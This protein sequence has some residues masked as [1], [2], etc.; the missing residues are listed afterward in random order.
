MRVKLV[1]ITAIM[2]FILFIH[3][4]LFN[5]FTITDEN[6]GKIVFQ[7]KIEKY[8][9]FYTSFT[10]SV[11]RTPVNE[12]Y[13]ISQGMFL[14]KKAAFYSYGAGMPEAGE[15]GSSQPKI[16]DG[17]VQ[18]DHIDKVF[19]SLTIFAGT[20]ADHS[21]NTKN[22]KISFSQLVKPQTSVTFEV[23]RISTFAIIRL[24]W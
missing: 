13:E 14:L 24:Q 3:I 22:K 16:V 1:C 17:L 6:S 23:K 7:D 11:N 20:Y 5:R 12:Y 15:Y 21:L 19:K 2:T 10:H 4:P 8:Q 9:N 18:I